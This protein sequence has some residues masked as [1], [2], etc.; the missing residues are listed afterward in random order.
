MF[1]TYISAALIGAASLLVGRAVFVASSRDGW[2]WIEPAAEGSGEVAVH[3]GTRSPV[4]TGDTISILAF[5]TFH[6]GQTLAHKPRIV[7]LGA[8]NQVISVG[9]G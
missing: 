9:E 5:A 7:T 2:T 3:S 1:G 8:N 4:R 6:E